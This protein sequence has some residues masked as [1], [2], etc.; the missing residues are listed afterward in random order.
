MAEALPMW[1]EWRAIETA[2]KDGTEIILGGC[3]NGA[4]VR[5]GH[6]GPTRY[7][8]RRQGYDRGWTSGASWGFKPTHWMPLPNPPSAS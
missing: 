4:S 6:W 3:T 8:G 5:V 1:P 7:L 2:P